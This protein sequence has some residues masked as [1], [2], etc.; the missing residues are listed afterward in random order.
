MGFVV[1]MVI[2]LLIPPHNDIPMWLPL[3]FLG[4]LII[5]HMILGVFSKQDSQISQII[6]STLN[7]FNKKIPRR[8]K[9]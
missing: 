2:F 7:I 3:A 9:V 6:I 8:L 5:S 4:L 1:S